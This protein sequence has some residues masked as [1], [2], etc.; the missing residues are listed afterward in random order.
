V[1]SGN[2]PGPDIFTA[3]ADRD[4]PERYH[5]DGTWV[6]HASVPHYLRKHGVPPET[7]LLGHIRDRQFTPPHV[8]DL[9][10]RTVAADLLGTPRPAPD[11]TEAVPTEADR[12]ARWET[13]RDPR[14]TDEDMLAVLAQRIAEHGVWPQAYRVGERADEAWCLNSTARGWEVAVHE[15]GLPVDPVYFARF[16]DA[17][18]HLLGALLMFPARRTAGY[19]T[20]VETGR[21]LADWPIQPAEGEPPLTLLRNK[22]MLRLPAGTEVRRFGGE[23]GNLVHH[24]GVRFP[25]TSLPLEREREQ[26]EYRLLRSLYVI[27]G[28]TIA[29]AN[30]PGGAVAYVLGKTIEEHLAEGSLE[31]I[32]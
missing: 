26:R 30:L 4:V 2:E 7:E 27:T 16:A 3:G 31:R 21:A 20:P 10:R 18:Q 23:R 8:E 5:T 22:R 24:G 11:A 1:F 25:T 28:V 14:L 19:Q 9:V 13:E 6:W 32:R 29:W 17:A 12:V 15:G